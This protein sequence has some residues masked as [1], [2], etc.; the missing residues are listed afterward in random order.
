MRPANPFL[1]LVL[2][3]P[4]VAMY[5]GWLPATIATCVA[6][7][8]GYFARRQAARDDAP[9]RPHAI[10]LLTH[11]VALLI[12]APVA[13]L[14]CGETIRAFVF[15]SL[16]DYSSPISAWMLPAGAIVL[17]A[18]VS[19]TP[20]RFTS[21]PL[22]RIA[23]AVTLVVLIV[24]AVG[25]PFAAVRGVAHPVFDDT[26]ARTGTERFTLDL[27]AAMFVRKPAGVPPMLPTILLVVTTGALVAF[28]WAHARIAH[29]CPSPRRASVIEACVTAFALVACAAGISMG[30]T[31]PV[32]ESGGG[33]YSPPDYSSVSGSY[34]VIND[35]DGTHG[36]LSEFRTPDVRV[37]TPW[38]YL[39]PRGTRRIAH[40]F[41]PEHGRVMGW[42]SRLPAYFYEEFDVLTLSAMR[43]HAGI[44][45]ED[46]ERGYLRLG[47]FE[48]NE[49]VIFDTE[50][51]ADLENDAIQQTFH[52][53]SGTLRFDRSGRVVTL[54]GDF[55]YQKQ[56]LGFRTAKNLPSM[57]EAVVH[58]GAN[59]IAALGPRV[60]IARIVVASM[61]ALL[62]FV[63]LEFALRAQ[64]ATIRAIACIFVPRTT[65]PAC[66]ACGYDMRGVPASSSRCPECGESDDLVPE[67]ETRALPFRASPFNPARW[68]AWPPIAMAV[69][70]LPLPFILLTPSWSWGQ[71]FGSW[72]HK[73][74]AAD[75]QLWFPMI[76]ALNIALGVGLILSARRTRSSRSIALG[77][78][79]I[80]TTLGAMV[81][82]AL[83]V[84]DRPSI[85]FLRIPNAGFAAPIVAG[86]VA[87]VG[88]IALGWCCF[89]AFHRNPPSPSPN[90]PPT[91]PL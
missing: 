65:G 36:F 31:R 61:V 9:P 5:W 87:F 67:G 75:I 42:G 52:L 81:W 50:V 90:N 3:G 88:L 60:E 58:G 1:L 79:I 21:L 69:A 56:Y 51:I 27:V 29:T 59:L 86:L 30:T 14:V 80:V 23:T 83:L 40:Y 34:V 16:T 25:L 82:L 32:E 53:P 64:R 15:P 47:R 54:T 74:T 72:R 33:G 91:P 10:S 37:T 70:L 48:G 66:A 13:A 73:V 18:I 39:H 76:A 43:Y 45:T 19:F 11:C 78:A 44:L 55:T 68:I 24:C 2:L 89:A 22:A 17:A 28:P 8:I 85:F 6:L 49:R 62:A 20:A 71:Q 63:T 46:M 35:I 38:G 84:N 7:A 77:V 4:A 26:G 41:A 57:G 12:L